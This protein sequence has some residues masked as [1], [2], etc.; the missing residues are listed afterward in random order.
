MG[1]RF[2]Q[3][4]NFLAEY[5]QKPFRSLIRTL[6]HAYLIHAVKTSSF[7]SVSLFSLLLQTDQNFSIGFNSGEYGGK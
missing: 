3:S 6:L 5:L 2:K 1:L 7:K 4:S